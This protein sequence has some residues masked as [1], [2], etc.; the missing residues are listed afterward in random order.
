MGLELTL[1]VADLIIACSQLRHLGVEIR[2]DFGDLIVL[3]THG[4]CRVF[5]DFDH[6]LQGLQGLGTAH[7]FLPEGSSLLFPVIDLSV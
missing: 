6:L 7:F 4:F 5:L 3:F 1:L 2:V